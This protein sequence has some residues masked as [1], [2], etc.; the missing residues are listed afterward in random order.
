LTVAWRHLRDLIEDVRGIGAAPGGRV[1][2]PEL[3]D[4][5][6]GG[7]KLVLAK[8]ISDEQFIRGEPAT[9]M[10][11]IGNACIRAFRAISPSTPANAPSGALGVRG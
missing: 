8:H 11:T 5:V 6:V 1:I 10:G 7:T 2:D 3:L 9:A 4:T